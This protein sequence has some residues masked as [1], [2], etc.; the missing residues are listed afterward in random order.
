MRRLLFAMVLLF[1][2]PYGAQE[3]DP[4]LEK[5]I[6]FDKAWTQFKLEYLGCPSRPFTNSDGILQNCSG[7]GSHNQKKFKDAKR[8]AE[9]LFGLVPEP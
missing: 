8:E 6:R 1:M 4:F 5:M 3:S 9:R 2:A 7:T